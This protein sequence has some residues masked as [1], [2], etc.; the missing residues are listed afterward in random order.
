ME[1]RRFWR[2]KGGVCGGIREG[3]VGSRG[4]EGV[5]GGCIGGCREREI[6]V[7]KGV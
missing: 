7:G 5:R 1:V 4:R 3:F 6:R 2:G